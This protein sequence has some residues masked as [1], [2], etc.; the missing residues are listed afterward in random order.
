MHDGKMVISSYTEIAM[1][2][3]NFLKGTKC[4]LLSSHGE[5]QVVLKQCFLFFTMIYAW[6]NFTSNRAPR[7]H[8]PKDLQFFSFLEVYSPSPGSQKEKILHPRAR[9]RPHIRFLIHLFYPYKCKTTYFHN[10]GPNLCFS[11]FFKSL[12]FVFI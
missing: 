12:V 7:V 10:T 3:N 1:G 6:F 8:S 5:Q 9:D 11:I 2:K 4:F